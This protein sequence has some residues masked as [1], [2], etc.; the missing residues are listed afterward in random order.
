[1]SVGAQHAV[2]PG[3]Y[4]SGHEAGGVK[5]T[6][7]KSALETVTPTLVSQ[8]LNSSLIAPPLVMS[9]RRPCP[10]LEYAR[11]FRRVPTDVT[12]VPSS[13][14]MSTSVPLLNDVLL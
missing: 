5:A 14:S 1:M 10:L 2:P 6:L 4:A 3:V 8:E 11:L 7:W 9:A 12:V 13:P